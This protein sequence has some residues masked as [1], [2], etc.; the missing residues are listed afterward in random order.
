MVLRPKGTSHNECKFKMDGASSVNPA[1]DLLAWSNAS[2]PHKKELNF[3][4]WFSEGIQGNPVSMCLMTEHEASTA[5]DGRQQNQLIRGLRLGGDKLPC[6]K[7]ALEEA[8]QGT[9]ACT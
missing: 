4:V 3:T 6:S 9:K 2:L 1:S 7:I 8:R 5:S